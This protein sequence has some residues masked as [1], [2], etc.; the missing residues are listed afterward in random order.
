M[1]IQPIVEGHGDVKALPILLRRFRHEAEAWDVDIGKP[2]RRPRSRLVEEVGIGQA[3]RLALVQPDC[4]AVL[5]LFDGDSD[6]PADL[7]P[8]V[9]NWATAAADGT[10]CHVVLAHREYEAWFLAAIES[11][12]G[13]RGVKIDAEP[14][15]A[16]ERP[17]G[18]KEQ[19]EA[20]MQA[21]ATYLETTDQ[22]AFSAMF[23]LAAAHGRSRSF[24][25]LAASFS[26]L[27][28]AMGHEIGE[29]PPAA[30]TAGV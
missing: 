18:A 6:C 17:R 12:R 29:W 26:N 14:H 4:G 10:P 30:W 21:G 3:V 16:P 23:S 24:R 7:G 13:R 15:P 1:N 22:P 28:R 11:L 20:R 8:T 9:Q 27:V 25:K 5:I 2:I 19:L